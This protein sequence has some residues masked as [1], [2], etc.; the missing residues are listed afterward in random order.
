MST[1]AMRRKKAKEKRQIRDPSFRQFLEDVRVKATSDAQFLDQANKL[2][3]RRQAHERQADIDLS[4]VGE[5]D[6]KIQKL[7]E[8]NHRHLQE[9]AFRYCTEVRSIQEWAKIFGVHRHTILNWLRRGDVLH[10]Q[11]VLRRNRFLMASERQMRTETLAWKKIMKLLQYPIS[12]EN[13]AAQAKFV[14]ELVAFN[15]NMR[16]VIQA[17]VQATKKLSGGSMRDVSPAVQDADVD[18]LE[19]IEDAITLQVKVEK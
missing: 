9:F 16:K 6:G 17:Q 11:A 8:L 5:N 12:E 19:E 15:P 18:D 10:F 7:P 14:L 13:Y 3:S 4:D 2:P 1:A